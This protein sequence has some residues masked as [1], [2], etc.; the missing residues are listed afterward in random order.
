MKNFAS[1]LFVC[2]LTLLAF[3]SRSFADDQISKGKDALTRGDYV[4]AIQAFREASQDDK[5]NPEA[6]LLLGK[7]C[8]MADSLEQA[9]GPLVQAR[10]LTP[11]DAQIY[12][13]LGDVYWKQKIFA[14]ALEQY[15]HAADLD[16]TNATIWLKIA[17]GNYKTRKWNEARDAYIEVIK[18]DSTNQI[19]LKQLGNI[20]YKAKQWKNALP[21]YIRLAKIYPDSLAIQ[22]QFVKVLDANE[23]CKDA[24]PVAKWVLERNP[25]NEEISTIYAKCSSAMGLD[26]VVIQ[27]LEKRNADSLK[28]DDLLTLAKAY[29]RTGMNEKAIATF[30]H[31]LRKDSTRCDVPYDLGTTYMK[32]KEYGKA[33]PM[34]KKKIACDT[35]SGYQFASHLNIAMS[36]MQQ[37]DFRGAKEYAQGSLVFRPEN[38]QAWQV[39]A[40]SYGQIDQIDS[41]IVTYK[42]VVELASAANEN[43][44]PGK[45]N[46]QLSESYRMI[47]VRYLIRA[48]NMKDADGAKKLYAQ[49]TQ[50]LTKAV[51]LDPK[52]CQLLQWTAQSFQNSNNKEEAGKY[53]CKLIKQCPGSKEAVDAKKQM[54]ALGLKCE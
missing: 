47:G 37:K 24:I 42:K 1:I 5:K 25:D 44:D 41:E 38:I 18:R 43:G 48:V 51:V 15:K 22:T 32:V 52:N 40:Q 17:E 19:A 29:K 2:T 34:F 14:A 12:L 54:D 35:S 31:I 46:P 11:N 26:S 21:L 8:L 36:L 20:Y 6:F 9:V 33:V 3:A 10:E 45:Y 50:F 53:Y 27:E 13:T 39:L 4:K 23:F 30:L 49:A 7:A 28:V 16:S